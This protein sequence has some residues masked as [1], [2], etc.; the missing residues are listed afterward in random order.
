M[1][2]SVLSES[3]GMLLTSKVKATKDQDES[4]FIAPILIHIYKYNVARE[5]YFQYMLCRIA[6]APL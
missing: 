3:N 6:A 5:L 1:V 4:G 2:S